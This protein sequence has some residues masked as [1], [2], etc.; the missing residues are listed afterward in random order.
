MPKL[1]LSLVV[2]WPLAQRSGVAIPSKPLQSLPSSSRK[3]PLLTGFFDGL[4]YLLGF[5]LFVSFAFFHI[6]SAER[7][8]CNGWRKEWKVTKVSWLLKRSSFQ[9]LSTLQRVCFNQSF[10]F[11]FKL[12]KAVLNSFC[13]FSFFLAVQFTVFTHLTKI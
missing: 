12:L 6:Q 7:S 1:Q 11:L 8:I 10:L 5:C 13:S 2:Y 9:I 4:S 3:F